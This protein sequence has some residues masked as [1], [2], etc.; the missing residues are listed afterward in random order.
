LELAISQTTKGTKAQEL[1]VTFC[2]LFFSTFEFEEPPK[3]LANNNTL[4]GSG[5]SDVAIVVPSTTMLS[6]PIGPRCRARAIEDDSK[7]RIRIVIQPAIAAR[8]NTIGTRQTPS[9]RIGDPKFDKRIPSRL[10]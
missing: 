10:Y 7:R 1:L 4:A 3:P 5:T 6:M 9:R 8:L 2:G